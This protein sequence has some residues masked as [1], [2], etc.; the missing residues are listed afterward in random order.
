M[1]KIIYGH[2]LENF[3]DPDATAVEDSLESVWDDT[4]SN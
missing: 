2:T 3:L 1:E 4:M